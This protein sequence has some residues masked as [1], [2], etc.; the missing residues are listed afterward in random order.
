MLQVL[1]HFIINFFLS[2]NSCTF[3]RRA[4]SLALK[5]LGAIRYEYHRLEGG[6]GEGGRGFLGVLKFFEVKMGDGNNF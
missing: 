3:L 6:G 5:V 1:I 2:S 4:L